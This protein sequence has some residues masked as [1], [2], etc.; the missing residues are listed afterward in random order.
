[1]SPEQAAGRLDLLG[2]ASDVYGLG[3]TLYALLTGTTP[4]SGPSEH[5]V[6]TR[7]LRG[8]FP[9]PR[10]LR[11]DVPA[12]LEA[13][14]LKA[15]A[16]R[17]ED[18]YATVAELGKE[19]E[20][21]L[22]DQPVR[23]WPEPWRVRARR[24][25]NRHRTLVTATIAAFLVA[26]IG[27]S[28][29]AVLLV[30]AREQRAARREYLNREVRTALDETAGK[31]GELERKLADQK[32]AH[33]LLSDID[34]WA[35]LLRGA[36]GSW[37]RAHAL[38]AG[39]Q[40]LLDAEASQLLRALER[41]LAEQDTAWALARKLEDIW[42][43]GAAQ[44][45]GGKLDNRRTVRRYAEAF[46]AAGFAVRPQ[47]E[48]EAARR[49]RGSPLRWVLMPSLDHWILISSGG[50]LRRALVKVARTADP[51]PWRDRLRDAR[52]WKD[53]QQLQRLAKE[54]R[55]QEHSPQ[56]ISA[57]AAWLHGLGEDPSEVLQRGLR[58]YPRDFWLHFSLGETSKAPL[59][60]EGG[61]RAALAL[62][63]HC[64]PAHTNLGMVLREQ[65]NLDGALEH[66]R[67]AIRMDPTLVAAQNNL[68]A[69]LI[70]RN[71][72]K[73]ASAVL[74]RAI[75]LDPEYG[76]AHFNLA[77]SLLAERDLERAVKEFRKAV[78]LLPNEL[79][80]HR[81]LVLTLLKTAR[82]A[83]AR[84]VAGELLKRSA[85]DFRAR[86]T[87]QEV[88]AQCKT[89]EALEK[90]LAV[91][92]AEGKAPA[93]VSEQLAMADLCLRYKHYHATSA[94][95]YA[96]AFAA[97]PAVVA[98]PVWGY[99][100]SAAR[101]ALLAATGKGRE[102]TPADA[103]EAATLRSQAR[104]WLRADLAVF[105][106]LL[107]ESEPRRLLLALDQLAHWQQDPDFASIRAAQ[108]LAR[109]PDAERADW[110]TFWADVNRLFKRLRAL[111]V[112][113][114]FEGTLTDKTR[115][116]THVL[117]MEPGKRYVIDM[118]S[119]QLDSYLKLLDQSGKL[120]AENNDAVAFHPDA[121]LIYTPAVRG[122]FRIVATSPGEWGRGTY[123]LTIRALPEQARGPE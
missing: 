95:L 93:E 6:L 102:P 87:W 28:V 83:E 5:D 44:A 55:P 17:P 42:L 22:D 73:Q 91:L 120:L 89:L 26:L 74:R 72:H 97:D 88:V 103:S 64:S 34:Q 71:E 38:A 7:V 50:E 108:A 118:H 29:V 104:Q 11:A 65:R 16:L 37:R 56:V 43:D 66:F 107:R 20:R 8:D 39:E 61:F 12:P 27:A 10:Q 85:G 53:R 3:A 4:F 79:E 52:V 24:W 115:A 14:C 36:R 94:R 41:R 49:I 105:A 100:V 111:T 1:M 68:G 112:E 9:R 51:D 110:Q 92:L 117:T 2:P 98:D 76:P 80:V 47:G 116:G 40:E 13:I 86:L 32:Q 121:R 46:A 109:L 106:G 35:T 67:M 21:W 75:E 113:T 82:F 119:T 70:G 48:T 90:K 78:R 57:L 60:R 59:Q 122:S 45:I 77:V 96:A 123:T 23:A 63:P 69:E 101:A 114:T 81:G 84:V 30:S 54:M 25:M 99:R 62:R 15:M 33:E 19:I 18:R 31:L 58:Q